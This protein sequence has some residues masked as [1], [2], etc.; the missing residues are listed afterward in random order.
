MSKSERQFPA[1]IDMHEKTKSKLAFMTAVGLSPLGGQGAR[2]S[3][4]PLNVVR[5][6]RGLVGGAP[7]CRGLSGLQSWLTD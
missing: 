1:H 6:R 7:T 3:A 4:P 5:L 2:R